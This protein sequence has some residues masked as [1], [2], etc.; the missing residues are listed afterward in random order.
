[1]EIHGDNN[2]RICQFI[3]VSTFLFALVS[4]GGSDD[5]SNNS[6]QTAPSTPT[7]LQ[8]SAVTENSITLGWNASTDNVATTGYRVIRNNAE[9]ATTATTDYTDNGL[10]S[11]TEYRYQVVAYDAAGNNSARSKELVQSTTSGAD[12]EAPSVPTGLNASDVTSS[13]ITLNWSA[14]SDNVVTTG[15]QIFRDG[16]EVATATTTSYVDSGLTASTQYQYTVSAY[17]AAGNDSAQSSAIN[18][19]TANQTTNSCGTQTGS[20][21]AIP[22]TYVM[23]KNIG[24]YVTLSATSTLVEYN[25]HSYF[26]A[27][28]INWSRRYKAYKYGDGGAAVTTW[29]LD[30]TPANGTLYEGTTALSQNDTI[31]DPDDLYY[32]PDTGFVG[33]DSFSYC[34]ADATGLSNTAMVSL[35][36]ADS[37]NYP[38]PIGVPDPGFGIDETPPA[39][40]ASWPGAETTGYYY[41]DADSSACSDNND[42]GY[43][44]KPRCSIPNQAT[45]AAGAKMVLAPSDE[46]YRLRDFAWHQVNFS[47][48]DTATSWLVGEEKGPDKPRIAPHT[49]QT[50]SRTQFRITGS[51]LRISGVVFD[52]P[53]LNHRGG[54]A[55]K[56]VLRHSEVRNNPSIAGG[57]TSVGLSTGGNGVLAFNVYAHDNGIVEENGLSMERDI[58]AFVGYDQQGYWILDSRCDEN[59]GDCVQLTNN[60]TTEDVYVGRLV[61]HSEGENCVDI[62]DFNRVVVSESHCWDLRVVNYDNDDGAPSN[63]LAQS[64]YVNNEGVQQN[65]TYFL[66]NRSWD[67]GGMN[68]GVSNVGGRVYYIGN[69]SFASPEADGIGFLNGGGSRYIYFNTVSDNKVGMYLYN[70]GGADDRYIAA[71]V[72]DGAALYQ[73][74]LDA[75]ASEI[76][77]L[78]YNFYTDSGGNFASGSSTLVEYNGLT[79]FQG[80]LGFSANSAEGVNA[81]FVN[82]DIHDY[83]LGAA[84]E[85]I[86]SVPASF[87][88]NQPVLTD[89]FND[90]GITLSD[91]AGTSRPQGTDYEAG[92]FSYKP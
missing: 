53:V 54:G 50:G 77:T 41:I 18:V 92:A 61:A 64:F 83:R 33:T 38:M 8:A 14:S 60:N 21:V 62:K 10:S 32:E 52:G 11:N 88:A 76:D 2:Q 47:G 48:T 13:S 85:L 4:C 58:H 46:P 66:N 37:A 84:T 12:T 28:N 59:A 3:L 31:S 71:N 90:L 74:H 9:I 86:D 44:D 81:A 79:E 24:K 91:I 65:Y 35:Q 75:V 7:G 69:Y 1:M 22:F 36:V 56:V 15:Y 16:T 80:A 45:I 5:T 68:F 19:T 39:D 6:D 55:D 20:I 23:P 42:Y 87:I 82:P 70:A 49:N 73:T 72:I 57:G 51:Y 78:D 30:S 25:A 63:G 26:D 43:P 34:A 29:R 27:P 89:L 67:T 17:D 40:P